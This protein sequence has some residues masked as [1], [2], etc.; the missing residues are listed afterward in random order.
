LYGSLQAGILAGILTG[1]LFYTRNLLEV[2]MD[3][4]EIALEISVALLDKL[5][6]DFKFSDDKDAIVG[7][8]N[9]LAEIGAKLYKTTLKKLNEP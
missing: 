6:Y 1:K 5:D 7:H 4:T 8:T 2:N 9:T 3:I